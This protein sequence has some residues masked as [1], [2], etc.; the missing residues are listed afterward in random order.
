VAGAQQRVD[1]GDDEIGPGV[2]LH[3]RLEPVVLVL[4]RS[5]SLRCVERLAELLAAHED[6]I[7]KVKSLSPDP[8]EPVLELPPN[9]PVLGQHPRRH[10][11]QGPSQRLARPFSD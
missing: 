10:R 8:L 11:L 6:L 2:D 1:L 3:E 5:W 9:P 7:E 4:H